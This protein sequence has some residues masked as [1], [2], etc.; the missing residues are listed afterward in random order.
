MG[1]PDRD[2]PRISARCRLIAAL[3]AAA[4]VILAAGAGC[5]GDEKTVLTVVP[6]GSLLIP[7]ESIEAG[8]EALHPEIDVQVEGH[9]SIQA[10]RQV[11]DLH[12]AIDVVAV[13]DASLIPEMMY[14]P[15]EGG[16]GNYADSYTPFATNEMV[17]AYTNRSRYA[18]E[19][20]EGNW[21]EI[22]AR[23]D[24]R[25]GF[26]NPMLDACGYRALMVTRLAETHYKAPGL[27]ARMITDH[28][29]PAPEVT[30]SGD[31]CTIIL[32][33]LMKPNSTKLAI[34]DGSVYLLALLDNGGIDYAFEY[35][36]V[37]R[38]HGLLW[39]DLPPALDLSSEANAREYAQVR[40]TLGFE[41][42][43]SI[44]SER[45][46]RPIVYAVTIPAT[47]PHPAEAE[48]FVDYMLGRFSEGNE[49]WPRPLAL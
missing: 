8:Y 10:V 41:R 3:A 46:G 42:F 35:E 25:V 44:G 45:T 38:E 18:G 43:A 14:I 2:P 33:E 37:A 5:T 48:A 9:G 21:Y 32:P 23:P 40:V 20:T 47:A 11:T 12:R 26:S 31:G 28:L 29:T 49:N 36:S 34:R 7:F 39:I 17:I 6:A 13:A 27:L 22:L 24:V 16:V 1:R 4:L 19:I 30:V 15:V